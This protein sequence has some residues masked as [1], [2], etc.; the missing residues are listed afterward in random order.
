MDSHYPQD[1]TPEEPEVGAAEGFLSRRTLL[2]AGVGALGLS[3]STLTALTVL[4][5]TPNRMAAARPHGPLPEI[6]YDIS[7]YIAP[8]RTI[9]GVVFRF[10]PVYTLFVTARLTRRPTHQEQVIMEEALRTI[11]AAY[12]FSPKGI[13][14]TI[15]Y[16]LPYFK[17]LARNVV[18]GHM[19]RLLTDRTR[20]A[21]EEA[22][23]GP[24]D[25]APQN[26]G[27]SK[28]KYNVPVVIEENDVLLTLR[29]DELSHLYDV[30][31]WLKGSNELTGRRVPSP[32]FNGLLLFT[33]ERLMFVQIGLPRQ[34]ANTNSLAY[35][36]HIN[37]HSPMWMGFADQQVSGSGAATCTAFQGDASARFT[38]THKGDYFFNGSIQH[39]SHVI[40]DLAQFYAADEPYTE[41]C[42]Y[43]FRSN[44]IPSKGNKDQYANG[45]GPAFLE[46]IYQGTHDAL[47]NAEAIHTYQGEHRMGHISALQRSSRGAD[48]KPAHIRADGPGF[49]SMDVPDG[50][51]Q[52]K[53]QFSIFVPT[54]EFFAQL[55][56]NQ[57]ALDLVNRYQVQDDDNGLE[58]FITATRRQN[59][60]VPPR[61]HRSFPLLELS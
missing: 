10:G 12:E 32:A 61:A 5:R 30:I 20:V 43:M 37:P 38:D 14:T 33:S 17:R 42:Q 26:P 1:P 50:S 49:D 53:L 11:E 45:G 40:Q 48:G 15:S 22:V 4:A 16:G 23:P 29:S 13:F 52:P 60:L 41:R 55:R 21:L 35:A 47:H 18:A 6:Q 46:N 28:L 54:A 24:T 2:K 31:A 7:D 3:A 34:L 51:S 9:D 19:P 36:S 25:I 57:A 8:A 58:R 39:L 27:I 44:P 56:K 59:F